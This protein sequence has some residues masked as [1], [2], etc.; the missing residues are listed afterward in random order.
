M[1]GLFSGVPP[2]TVFYW[3]LM[4]FLKYRGDMVKNVREL[5]A[6]WQSLYYLEFCYVWVR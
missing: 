5:Q 2:A 3:Q 1:R 4:Q 6:W